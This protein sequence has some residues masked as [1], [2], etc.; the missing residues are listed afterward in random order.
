MNILK[1][2]RVKRGFS[3]RELA[4]KA[5]INPSTISK[6][7]SGEHPTAQLKTVMK[8]AAALERPIEDFES[9]IDTRAAQRGSLGGQATRARRMTG[10]SQ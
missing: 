5:G 3:L 7:E 1:E 8:L 2:A 6:L 10:E 9:L 4:A